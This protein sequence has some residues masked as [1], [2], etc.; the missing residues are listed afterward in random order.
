[1][2]WHDWVI[3][4][5][6]VPHATYTRKEQTQQGC[7]ARRRGHAPSRGNGGGESEDSSRA[8]LALWLAVR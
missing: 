6:E 4:D 2:G 7:P 8:A 1:M 3:K 5:K